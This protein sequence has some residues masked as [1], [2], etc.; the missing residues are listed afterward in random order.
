MTD[1]EFDK[2]T[3]G[4]HDKAE[5]VRGQA[6]EALDQ[7]KEALDDAKDAAGHAAEHLGDKLGLDKLEKLTPK[8]VGDM[9]LKFASETAFAAAGFAS[10]V[11]EKAREFAEKQ[12]A[13]SADVAPEAGDQTKAFLDQFTSQMNRFVDELGH[14]YKDLADRGRDAV[15][16]IQQQ[17]AAKPDPKDAPGMFDIVDDAETAEPASTLAEEEAAPAASEDVKEGDAQ[18]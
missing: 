7:A 11:A 15:S 16:K 3:E 14:T 1:N 17:A 10:L 12:R 6:D 9:A 8:E 18:A 2:T 4:L 5:Q 13:A